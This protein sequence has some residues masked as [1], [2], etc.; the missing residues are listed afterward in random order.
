MRDLSIPRLPQPR[1]LLCSPEYERLLDVVSSSEPASHGM[2]LL[3]REVMRA[4]V[5]PEAHAPRALVRLNSRVLYRDLIARENR[6]VVV[7]HPQEANGPGR[8]RVDSEIGAAL[9]GLFEGD[10]FGWTDT[11]GRTQLIR[12]DEVAPGAVGAG[13]SAATAH[14]R[15]GDSLDRD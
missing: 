6:E 12:V 11:L 8:V 10:V 3:W 1:I 15:S 14:G 9:I 13:Q 5:I 7:A 2:S 4:S